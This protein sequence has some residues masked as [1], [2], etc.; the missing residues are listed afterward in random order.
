[1]LKG[2]AVKKVHFPQEH[3]KN[4]VRIKLGSGKHFIVSKERVLKK[5]EGKTHWQQSR[6]GAKREFLGEA[7]GNPIFD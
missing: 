4:T 3:R 6:G 5:D 7:G 1:V 2:K